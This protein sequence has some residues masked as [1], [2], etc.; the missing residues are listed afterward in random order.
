LKVACAAEIAANASCTTDRYK[1]ATRAHI[2]S[3]GS[4]IVANFGDQ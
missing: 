3:L 1:T 4:D 2:E